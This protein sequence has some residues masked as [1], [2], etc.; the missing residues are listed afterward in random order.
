LPLYGSP[1]K[2]RCAVKKLGV[3]HWRVLIEVKSDNS[4]PLVLKGGFRIGKDESLQLE[5]PAL[6]KLF[7]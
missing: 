1:T 2:S 4:A 7:A 6:R 3:G 5:G